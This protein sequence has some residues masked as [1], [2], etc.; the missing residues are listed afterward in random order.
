[1]TLKF[2]THL[3]TEYNNWLRSYYQ[4]LLLFSIANGFVQLF[5]IYI[6]YNLTKKP[7]VKAVEQS[8]TKRA[9]SDI[10]IER[11]SNLE[12]DHIQT[13]IEK[14]KALDVSAELGEPLRDDDS[15]I[16]KRSFISD[17]PSQYSRKSA[18]FVAKPTELSQ[19]TTRHRIFAQFMKKEE[20]ID[21]SV[22]NKTA[23]TAATTNYRETD[24]DNRSSRRGSSI[25][26]EEYQG[27]RLSGDFG[28]ET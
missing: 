19:N 15:N 6:F 13:A 20:D 5:T 3:S 23:K 9:H 14:K 1:V 10:S 11:L 17:A 21:Q 27:A 2:I 24:E 16:E 28:K 26:D 8:S 18:D 22:T 25:N 7:Q 4:C 12:N